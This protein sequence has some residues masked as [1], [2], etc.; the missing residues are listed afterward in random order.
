MEMVKFPLSAEQI[1]HL[2]AD[3]A[4]DAFVIA[5]EENRVVVWSAYAETLFGWTA[6]EAVGQSLNSLIIPPEHHAAH[7][8][9][10]ENHVKTERQ[11]RLRRRVEVTALHK[12]GHPVE[13]E[14]TVIP[15]KFESRTYFAASIRDNSERKANEEKLKEQ[16][17]LLNLSRDAIMVLSLDDAVLWW[18]KGAEIMYGIS[19]EQAVGKKLYELLHTQ[20]PVPFGQFKKN[21]IRDGYWEGEIIHHKADFTPLTVLCRVVVKRNKNKDHDHILVSATDITHFKQSRLQ[22]ILLNVFEQR[23]KALFNDHADGVFAMDT[24]PRLISANAA[25]SAMTGYSVE[26]LITSPRAR[27]IAPEMLKGIDHYIAMVLAGQPQTCE[28]V[29]IRKDGSRFDAL[30]TMVPILVDGDVY[31]VHGLIK[32]I[33][34]QKEIER[35]T[36]FAAHHDQLTGLPNRHHLESRMQYAIEQA[37]RL[38]THIGVLFMDL[39]KFK[40]VNDTFG[41]E[42]GDRLLCA[43][44]RRLKD[45]VREIDTV[46]R[47]GGDEFVLLIENVHHDR[48]DLSRVAE[49]LIRAISRPF[50]VAGHEL[51]ISTS[52]GA[53]IFP[54][55]GNDLETLI[56][57]ADLA[58]YEAKAAG[59][60]N[61]KLYAATSNKGAEGSVT[62]TGS[63]GRALKQDELVL[64]YQPRFNLASRQ[65]VGVEALVRWKHPEKGLIYPADFLADIENEGLL[66]ELDEWV[67]E[68]ACMENKAWHSKGY[69][70]LK[71][72]VNLSV[73]TR[74]PS[75]IVQSISG[76]LD[77]TGFDPRL[78][79]IEINES[80]L[81]DNQELSADLLRML[82]GMGISTS[83]DD[84]GTGH[85]SIAELMH[86]ETNAIKIDSSFI[87]HLSHEHKQAAIVSATIAM[88]HGMHLKVVAEGVSSEDEMEFLRSRGCDEIQGYLTSYPLPFD[89]TERFLS[90]INRA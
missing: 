16:V 85:C 15:V 45:G 88:A 70:P 86:L 17:E 42:I 19:R 57:L 78:L 56:K 38:G 5:N 1:W 22:Q 40:Q 35:K 37:R 81:M 64:H 13:I 34:R 47:I 83:I 33:S 63:L 18:N 73:G 62:F 41:H 53:S 46:A 30:A 14:L 31:G 76:I 11:S 51:V 59:P 61:F 39:N 54:L 69:K 65:A 77:K 6:E 55:H 66:G 26:E 21:L 29:F 10:I 50:S 74:S 32:D 58:M 20:F 8:Q 75:E 23:F 89:K 25:L 71:L 27:I 80:R 48:H 72:S 68:H 44:A 28:V 12:D 52:I 84:F 7:N 24:R 90:H 60:G 4:I 3:D 43:V 79:D 49:N 9:G 87:R 2:I 82:R 67:L 36:Y